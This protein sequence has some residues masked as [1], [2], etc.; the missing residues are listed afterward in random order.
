[1]ELMELSITKISSTQD[2]CR[3]CAVSPRKLADV[4]IQLL[5]LPQH[6]TSMPEL[7]LVNCHVD[8]H[9]MRHGSAAML[10][11]A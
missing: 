3:Q 10:G 7:M 8:D 9:V 1:M 2:T 4:N 5:Y 11:D 6:T